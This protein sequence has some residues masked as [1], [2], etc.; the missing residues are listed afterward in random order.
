[1]PGVAELCQL[2][3]ATVTQIN[4]DLFQTGYATVDPETQ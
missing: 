2:V 1:M 3:D 4:K